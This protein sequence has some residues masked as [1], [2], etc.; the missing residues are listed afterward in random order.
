MARV[1][2][3]H[4]VASS[5]ARIVDVYRDTVAPAVGDDAL[6]DVAVGTIWEVVDAN[7]VITDRFLCT[8]PTAGAAVWKKMSYD[9]ERRSILFIEETVTFTG[10]A[11]KNLVAQLPARA[12]PIAAVMNMDTLVVCTTA[13]KIGVGTAADPDGYA[14]TAVLTKNAKQA[15][16]QGKGALC[17]IECAV[18]TTIQVS[19]VDINGAA[20]GTADSGTA[21]VR[22]YYELWD[23]LPDQP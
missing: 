6:D 9:D 11:S 16:G 18:A 15:D 4:T 13:V 3:A 5:G 7:E 1:R 14:K 19:A 12:I 20:A 21:R 10:S 23:K 22:V 17:G 8:D 2:Q